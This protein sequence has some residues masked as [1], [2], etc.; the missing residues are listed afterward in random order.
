ME[1]KEPVTSG[2]LLQTKLESASTDS[3]LATTISFIKKECTALPRHELLTFLPMLR[4][5]F[6]NHVDRIRKVDIGGRNFV[7]PE[8][9]INVNWCKRVWEIKFGQRPVAL[10]SW[11]LIG[12]INFDSS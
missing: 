4:E 6:V 1:K 9:S 2:H 12:R 11:V 3:R 5:T 8:K 7:K 10:L